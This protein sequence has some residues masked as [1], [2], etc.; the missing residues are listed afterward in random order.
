M[1][2]C[3]VRF[4]TRMPTFKS[5]PRIRSA[6]HNRLSAAMRWMSSIVSLDIFAGGF[7][8]RERIRQESFPM[9]PQNRVRLDQKDGTLPNGFADEGHHG[10]AHASGDVDGEAEHDPAADRS[11]S[12]QRASERR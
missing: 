12:R 8:R 7:R 6:P 5:S 2:F 3:T 4:E 11:G 10:R 1:C 9:P